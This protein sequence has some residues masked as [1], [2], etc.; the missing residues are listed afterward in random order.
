M[1]GAMG[2]MLGAAALSDAAKKEGEAKEDAAPGVPEIDGSFRIVTDGDILA[3]NTDEGPQAGAGG[4][5]LQWRITKRTTAA[6]M[7][8]VRLVP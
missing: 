6:P 4:K 7:A 5:V 2:S 1:Q 8:L 3:N